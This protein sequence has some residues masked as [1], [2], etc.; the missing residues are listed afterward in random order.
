MTHHPRH[1]LEAPLLTELT[2]VA[3]D[4]PDSLL[5]RLRDI[6]EEGGYL[7]VG[8]LARELVRNEV[9]KLRAEEQRAAMLAVATAP[10]DTDILLA[11][12]VWMVGNM[13]TPIDKAAWW[14]D[15]RQTWEH[16][17]VVMQALAGEGVNISAGIE[18]LKA[19]LAARVED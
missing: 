9:R 18:P 15:N 3:L 19:S 13:D 12:A 5:D 10:K 7:T 4:L 1:D 17:A 16:A 6:A 2:Q 14:A 8:E 11:Y